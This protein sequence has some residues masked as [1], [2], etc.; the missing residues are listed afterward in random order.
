MAFL[1]CQPYFAKKGK[2]KEEVVKK[3]KCYVRF[4]AHF[5]LSEY[6]DKNALWNFLLSF[7]L[8]RYQHHY[9]L[10]SFVHACVCVLVVSD[11]AHVLFVLVLSSA[12]MML[13]R[14]C[15]PKQKLRKL[16]KK[17]KTGLVLRLAPS[18]LLCHKLCI[19]STF[20]SNFVSG[21]QHA[22]EHS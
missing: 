11:I 19:S 22:S 9:T 12:C 2:E 13:I 10:E 5:F 21:A 16:R 20:C 17:Q 3:T 15:R 18:R 7:S 4:I 8:N 14:A 1:L 6:T